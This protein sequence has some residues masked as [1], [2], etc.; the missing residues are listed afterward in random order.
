[1]AGN[2]RLYLASMEYCEQEGRKWGIPLS[3]PL[4]R[5]GP[6][7]WQTLIENRLIRT[8]SAHITILSGKPRNW[9]LRKLGGIGITA[10]ISHRKRGFPM[11][12][13][14]PQMTIHDF[15]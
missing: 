7:P 8:D 3:Y 2:A 9:R 1:M 14:C 12:H 11:H 4:S 6:L 5:S 10:F 15:I 13:A